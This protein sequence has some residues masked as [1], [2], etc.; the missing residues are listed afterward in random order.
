MQEKLENTIYIF[1]CWLC[2]HLNFSF[3]YFL[4]KSKFHSSQGYISC[5]ISRPH[6]MSKE[7]TP[8]SWQDLNGNYD[9][10]SKYLG[11]KKWVWSFL[12]IMQLQGFYGRYWHKKNIE[13]LLWKTLYTSFANYLL[14]TKFLTS[15]QTVSVRAHFCARTLKSHTCGCGNVSLYLSLTLSLSLSIGQWYNDILLFVVHI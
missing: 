2:L 5:F 1:F 13:Y 3:Y 12:Y 15:I 6:M 14:S 10:F 11:T 8:R 4:N 9:T 7:N